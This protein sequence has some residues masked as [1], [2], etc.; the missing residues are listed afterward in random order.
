MWNQPS[1]WDGDTPLPVLLNNPGMA[2][3]RSNM[4]KAVRHSSGY[5]EF[6]SPVD[7]LAIL[8]LAVADVIDRGAVNSEEVIY[9]W[10]PHSLGAFERRAEAR[11]LAR[12]FS[13]YGIP[14]EMRWDPVDEDS[15][16]FLRIL[17]LQDLVKAMVRWLCAGWSLKND[18]WTS[19]AAQIAKSYA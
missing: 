13:T 8:W 1:T 14:L 4:L 15:A 7:G 5:A 17:D 6:E 2:P 16:R 9:Q 11:I 12:R 18:V 10:L 19:A 3:H